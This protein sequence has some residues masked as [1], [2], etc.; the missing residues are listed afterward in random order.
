MRHQLSEPTAFR[1]AAA[2]D[3]E[4]ILAIFS[5]FQDSSFSCGEVGLFPLYCACAFGRSG[6]ARTPLSNGADPNV[7]D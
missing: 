1:I 6:A 7:I 3:N 2:Q 5:K 4:Q